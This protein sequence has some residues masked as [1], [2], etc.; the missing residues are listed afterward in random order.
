MESNFD[1]FDLKDLLLSLLNIQC[2]YPNFLIGQK[3]NTVRC[4]LENKNKV[5]EY[6]D[7]SV[8][9]IQDILIKVISNEEP[10]SSSMTNVRE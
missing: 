2:V 5:E 9:L 10:K 1:F 6:S 7:S 8:N 4:S 3:G